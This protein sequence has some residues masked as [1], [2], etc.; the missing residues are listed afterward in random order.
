M[1]HEPSTGTELVSDEVQN[2]NSSAVN[3]TTTGDEQHPMYHS[4]SSWWKQVIGFF[5]QTPAGRKRELSRRLNE[6]NVS[7]E[8]APNSPTNYVLRGELFLERQEYHLAQADFEIAL[9]LAEAFDAQAGW[10]VIEQVMRDRALEGLAKTQE[11]L[12]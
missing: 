4:P 3:D 11:Q 1:T 5:F 10:G 6:L 9:E 2:T 7:I 8:F 12:P